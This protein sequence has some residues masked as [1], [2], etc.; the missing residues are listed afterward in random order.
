[1]IHTMKDDNKKQ[2]VAAAAESSAVTTI[3]EAM[4]GQFTYIRQMNR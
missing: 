2:T 1:M 4:T 3:T